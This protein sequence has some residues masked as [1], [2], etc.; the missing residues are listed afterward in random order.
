MDKN[1]ITGLILI[2]VIF[3]GF[4]LFNRSRQNKAYEETIV[5]ADSYITQVI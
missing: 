1:T 3:I 4:S 5:V 2:F